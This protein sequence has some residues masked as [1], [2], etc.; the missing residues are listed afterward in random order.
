M[1][2]FRFT[3]AQTI[4]SVRATAILVRNGQIFLTR[5]SKDRYYPIGGA[6][7]V[8]ERT[9]TAVSRETMEELGIEI[10]VEKLAFIVENH[11]WDE[12]IYWHNIEFHYMVAPSQEP[13]LHLQEGTKIQLCEW[14]DINR[15][16]EIDLVPEFLKDKLPNW[17]GQLKHIINQ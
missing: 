15:L 14:I 12:G 4:S 1:N 17:D 10:I 16:S 13:D 5:D 6:V 7:H 2:D 11:F 8:G 3:K 9:E